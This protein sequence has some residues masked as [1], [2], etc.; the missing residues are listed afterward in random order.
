MSLAS[1]LGYVDDITETSIHGWVCDSNNL[2]FSVVVEIYENGVKIGETAADIYRPDLYDAGLGNGNHGFSFN[3]PLSLQ[4]KKISVKVKDCDYELPKSQGLLDKEGDLNELASF[5]KKFPRG[6]LPHLIHHYMPNGIPKVE[7]FLEPTLQ[8][9]QDVDLSICK[10]LLAS[11]NS[12][13]EFESAHI[14]PES[15][16][17]SGLW[18]MLKHEFHGQIYNLLSKGNPV[19]LYPM[20]SSRRPLV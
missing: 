4:S 2:D 16:P 20:K 19:E 3:F 1:I 7:Y 15:R 12:A 9:N 18:E 6:T 17:N 11:F 5:L 10:R 8:Q 14:K 13:L